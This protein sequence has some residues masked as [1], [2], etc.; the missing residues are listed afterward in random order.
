MKDEKQDDE[1]EFFH[2][3]TSAKDE[4]IHRINKKIL[5]LTLHDSTE[6]I[7]SKQEYKFKLPQGATKT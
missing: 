5:E 1:E 2:I 7:N 6:K 3:A 4:E